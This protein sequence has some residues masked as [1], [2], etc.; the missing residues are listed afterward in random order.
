MNE[1]VPIYQS[2][3]PSPLANIEAEAALLGALMIDNRLAESVMTDLLDEHFYEPVHGR[4]YAM[5]LRVIAQGSIASAVTLRPL[6]EHDAAMQQLGGVSYLAQLTGSSIVFLGA[7]DFARQITD[8]AKRRSLLEAI[9]QMRQEIVRVDDRP[10]EALVDGLDQALN[11]SLQRTTTTRSATLLSA[12]DTTMRSIE[13]EASGTISRGVQIDGWCDFNALTDGLRAGEVTVLAGRP[14][15]GKTA[16]ALA[17]VTGA[18]R[19]GHGTLFISLEM[20]LPELTKR[21]IA[22]LCFTDKRAPTYDHIKKGNLNAF[23]RERLAE[24]RNMIENWPLR[25]TDP[26]RLKIGNVAM[27]IRRYARLMAAAGQKLELVVIDYLGL[28]KADDSRAKRYEAVGEISRT[29]KEIAKECGVSIIILAQ[30]N[31]ECEKREDK[32]PM[33]SDLRDAGDI[34]QDADNVLFLFREQYYLEQIEPDIADM[35]RRPS[36]EIDMAAARDRLELIAAKVRSGKTGRRISY[37][38]GDHQA[39]RGSDFYERGHQ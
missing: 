28:V 5:I 36:W 11:A 21:V 15:M 3:G 34:E 7:R 20:T 6:F 16:A 17:V 31:R 8:L 14:G 4:I 10:V 33:L 30:L 9:D 12:F 24:V 32:R 18:A 25:L 1:V 26:A 39:I 37:F 2:D 29:V 13:D 22:D 35:K 19:A 23:D 38:F 27:Q